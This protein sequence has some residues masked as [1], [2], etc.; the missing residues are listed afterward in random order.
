MSSLSVRWH[1]EKG[2]ISQKCV[3][4]E[5]A[6]GASSAKASALRI[7]SIVYLKSKDR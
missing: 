7:V 3:K 1:H 6:I 2:A 4:V 5:P